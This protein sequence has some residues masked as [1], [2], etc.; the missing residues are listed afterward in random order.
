MYC[1]FGTT[2]EKML[3][4]R[5]V[6]GINDSRVR[7]RLLQEKDLN[8]KRAL[9]VAQALEVAERDERKLVEP[10]PVQKLQDSKPRNWRNPRK[11]DTGRVYGKEGNGKLKRTAE[12][13]DEK[14]AWSRT[15]N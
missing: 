1:N 9:E 10:E 3:R 13:D 2:L 11:E 12:T 8:F 7:K 15:R 4:D 14:W 6:G 5:L